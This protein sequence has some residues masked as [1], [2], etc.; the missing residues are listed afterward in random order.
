[1]CDAV[2]KTASSSKQKPVAHCCG[3]VLGETIHLEQNAMLDRT[4]QARFGFL[5]TG[6]SA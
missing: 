2:E 6:G 4:G 1:V 5:S 3:R